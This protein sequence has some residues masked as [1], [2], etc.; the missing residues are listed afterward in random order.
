LLQRPLVRIKV[1]LLNSYT[2]NQLIRT[3][4][5]HLQVARL[6]ILL[7]QNTTQRQR[8]PRD[9]ITLDLL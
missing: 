4:V 6:S 1:C 8:I 9:Q 3:T 5:I 7:F 2:T